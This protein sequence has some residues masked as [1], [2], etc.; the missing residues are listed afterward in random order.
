MEDATAGRSG[1]V[2]NCKV[3]IEKCKL[4]IE[5]RKRQTK[6]RAAMKF[7]QR[8]TVGRIQQVIRES[9]NFQFALFNF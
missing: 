5:F 4:Q 7:N 9:F 8:D 3:K 6:A 1:I 2:L